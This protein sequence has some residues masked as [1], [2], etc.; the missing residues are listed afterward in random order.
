MTRES[1]PVNADLNRMYDDEERAEKEYS[2]RPDAELNDVVSA[3]GD[4]S[5]FSSA[6]WEALSADGVVGSLGC[7]QTQIMS[8]IE[9]LDDSALGEIVRKQIVKYLITVAQPRLSM[10]GSV[11]SDEEDLIEAIL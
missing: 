6:F 8:C 3:I 2:E 10:I 1:C 5:D 9:N 4:D 7:T 11:K